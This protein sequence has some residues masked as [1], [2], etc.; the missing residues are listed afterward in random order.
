MDVPHKHCI[1]FVTVPMELLQVGINEHWLEV[2]KDE[3]H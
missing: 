3:L 2:D 1:V